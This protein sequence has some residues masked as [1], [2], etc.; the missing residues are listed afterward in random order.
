MDP[1]FPQEEPAA[2]WRGMASNLRQIFVALV[3]EGF[4]ENQALIIV[5]QTLTA[6]IIYGQKPDDD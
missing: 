5:G 3:Q 4:S 6:S 1:K 2:M